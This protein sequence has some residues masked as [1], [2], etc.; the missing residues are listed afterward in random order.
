LELITESRLKVFRRCQREHDYRYARGIVPLRQGESLVF[1]TLV[2]H[3]LEAWWKTA[4]RDERLAAALDAIA[5]HAPTEL[6]VFE[7]MRA[8]EMTRGYHFRWIDEPYETIAVEK[9]FRAPLVNPS[10]GAR[11]RTFAR[12]GKLDVLAADT[13]TGETIIV[14]H[15]TS[16]EDIS[17]GSAY[18]IRR[19]LDGQVS[20]YF[21]GAGALGYSPA[22]ACLYDVLGKPKLRPH[23]AT[24]VKERRFTKDG[25]LD[26]RQRATDETPEEFR[27]RLRKEIGA[28]PERYFQRARIVRLEA[29]M[30][31]HD[32][33]TWHEAAL[34]RESRRTARAPRNADACTRFGSTCGYYEVCR[35]LASLDDQGRF[36]QLAWPHP[37]LTPP[38]GGT[39][40]E[41][42]HE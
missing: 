9:E 24:P 41:V 33:D 21:R 19:E 42:D 18:W 29:Q 17:P 11:S 12:A 35:G 37:E 32:L 34:I 22:A 6:D 39:T 16:G 40:T 31:E 25:R 26:S 38:D 8:E 23:K 27:T 2:H 4:G 15:K 20:G 5:A 7:R 13:R 10:T 1:G 36:R 28:H 14:E 3:A 30:A